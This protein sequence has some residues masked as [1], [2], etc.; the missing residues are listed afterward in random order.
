MIP[1][2]RFP[3]RNWMVPAGLAWIVFLVWVVVDAFG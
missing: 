3:R 2:Y 1:P